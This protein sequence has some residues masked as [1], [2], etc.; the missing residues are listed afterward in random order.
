MDCLV[1]KEH[2]HI[3]VYKGKCCVWDTIYLIVAQKIHLPW[4]KIF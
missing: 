4:A 2:K 3:V 1:Y